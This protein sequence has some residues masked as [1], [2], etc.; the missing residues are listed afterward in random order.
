MSTPADSATP[1]STPSDPSSV[2]PWS[3]R[4]DSDQQAMSSQRRLGPL[5]MITVRLPPGA[6]AR[7]RVLA[8]VDRIQSR[9]SVRVLDVV[10]ASK[11]DD[12]TLARVSFGEDED[13]GDLVSQFF[14]PEDGTAV[15]GDHLDRM[16]TQAPALPAGTTVAFLLVTH[17]WAHTLFQV[18]DDVGGAVFSAGLLA[19][20]VDRAIAAEV[21]AMDDAARPIAQ[22]HAAEADAH[23]RAAAA[24]ADAD[25]AEAASTQIRSAAAAQALRALIDAGLVELAAAHE[26]ADALTAAGLIVAS[27]Y[28]LADRALETAAL[29]VAA[30]DKATAEVIADDSA[31]VAAADQKAADAARAASVT[32]AELRVLHYLP[33]PLTFA[34]IAEKLGI[35]RAAAKS[36]AERAYKT[37]RVHNRA[38]AVRT[39]RKLRVLP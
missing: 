18:I 34:L 25:N 3:R 4:D 14:P 33:T 22:A 36:R 11:N 17:Q 38:D 20:S 13:F 26:A 1:T 19:P 31:A 12:G 29:T 28:E 30:A 9:G 39:A 15:D 24:R 10:L 27:S 8:E 7:D 6:E 21:T 35:S 2:S 16:W 23:L 5:Q 32:P 37:L